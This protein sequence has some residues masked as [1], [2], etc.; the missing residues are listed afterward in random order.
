MVD[1][2]SFRSFRVVTLRVAS[3]VSLAAVAM[4]AGCSGGSGATGSSTP[5]SATHAELLRVEYGRLVDVYGLNVTATGSSIELYRRDVLIG[6]SIQDE[7]GV[8]STKSDDEI[9]YDFIGSDPDTLQPRLFIPRD[10]TGEEFADALAAVD[11]DVRTVTPMLYG[12][13]GSGAPF[14]VVP[15]N[16]A[17]RLLFSRSLGIDDGFFVERDGSGQIIGLR[18]TEAVQLL[19]IQGDP[20]QT[21]NVEPLPVRVVPG[22]NYLI[23]DPV[24]LGTEGLQY[25]TRNNASGL[26]EAPDQAS[27]NIR[28]ALALEGPLAIPNLRDTLGLV[29]PNNS[30]REAI[31][32][33]FRSGNRSDSSSDIANGFVRDPLP[34]RV[35][36]EIVMYVEEVEVL[37]EFTARVRVYKDGVVHEI[38]RGDVFR[39]VTSDPSAPIISADVVVDPIDDQGN[40]GEQHVDVTVRNEPGLLALDPS[41]LS[42]YP[43][44]GAPP[45]QLEEWLVLNAPKAICVAEFA[46]GDGGATTGDDPRN[47]LR[48][49]PEPLPNL[50]GTPPAANEFVSP[51]AGAV[52]R[53]TKPVAIETVRS[54]DTFFFAMR[55]LTSAAS[56][57]DFIDNAPNNLGT[58]GMNPAHFKDAKYRTP[59]LLTAHVYDED[60]S[61]TALRLQPSSGFFLND[62]MRDDALLNPALEYPFYLHLIANSTEGGIRD[63]AGNELDL[64]GTTADTSSSVVI[65]FTV[66]TRRNGNEPFFEDN[67]AISIV[68]RWADIDE[69]SRPSY[70]LASEVPAPEVQGLASAYP[71]EDLFGGLVYADGKLQPRPTSRSRQVADNLN[72]APVASQS[73]ILRWCPETVSGEAQIVTNT[74]TTLFGQGIQ[75]PLNPYGCRLQTV[76]REVDLSLSRTDPFEF[77]L[78]VEQMYWAPFTGSTLAFDEFDRTSLFLGHSEYRPQ[79]CIGNFSALP[80][81][82]NSG[83]VQ[84]FQKNFVWNPQPVGSGTLVESQPAP[85]PA[86]VDAP[87]TIDPADVVYEVNNV[88]RFLPLP[89]FE[90]PYFVFRDELV[91]EQGLNAG[92]GADDGSTSVMNPYILSPWNNGLGRR[93]LDFGGNVLL[94]NGFWNDL[95]NRAL[96]SSATDYFTGGLTGSIALPLLAD[97][98]TYCDSAELP[99]GNGYIAMGTNGWQIAL[100]V[101]SSPKP[102]FRAYSAGRNQPTPSICVSPGSNAWNTASGGYSGTGGTTPPRDNTFYW[103]MIDMLKRQSVITN[104]FI[105]INNPHRV[106]L[107]GMGDPRLGPFYL[108]P[109]TGANVRPVDI[110]PVF[111]YEFD[112]PLSDLP[113]GTSIVTQFRAAGPVD[114]TPW[115]WNAWVNTSTSL[116]PTLIYPT[117]TV[118]DQ[119]R[120]DATCFPL[121]PHIACDAHIRKWDVRGNRNWWTYFYNRNIT[122]YLEDPNALFEAPYVSQFAGPS[123]TFTPQDIRYVNW[124]FVTTNNVDA[125]PPISPTIETFALAWRYQRTQ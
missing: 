44:S 73:S 76:W 68:H 118:R 63:L 53:F 89:E 80:S 22:D 122:S 92:T 9:L 50:D 54:A 84:E 49:T 102:D 71:L 123:D 30:G 99:E 83:L 97:F 125:N 42:G 79:P 59:F 78:D 117:G 82:P 88:N 116:Y 58:T 91:I 85:H 26:P 32:R 115:Y 52:V 103:I 56:K 20:Q 120:P 60:S 21:G 90:K 110:A 114:S 3:A 24:L 46:A 69:D 41:N 40:P 55:D 109:T 86:Y 107:A 87:L 100:T 19:H 18:N 31:V 5:G 66:D 28:I 2:S 57:Q 33:D 96:G 34:L 6:P 101:Q 13:S 105:D 38:D 1:T 94:A 25:Q 35:V 7:R 17:I 93:W 70:F 15:R 36:G 65:P 81:L 23:L 104:G 4:V 111:T 16:A 98:W 74:S 106:P 61:A 113:G 12:T 112:P 72:Q 77:N 47:F 37:S 51:F 29:G 121:D 45:S 10:V 11:D 62:Q 75:N 124:R 14:G 108:N 119:M 95:N 8:N 64:Q 39:F 48:F 43:G 27:A 67:L